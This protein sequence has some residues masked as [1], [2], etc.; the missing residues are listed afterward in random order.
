MGHVAMYV[1]VHQHIYDPITALSV[2]A[3]QLFKVFDSRIEL[4]DSESETEFGFQAEA[5]LDGA[6]TRGMLRLA[7]NDSI[8]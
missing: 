2:Q 4:S 1:H 3:W 7:F 6:G 5:E 8:D